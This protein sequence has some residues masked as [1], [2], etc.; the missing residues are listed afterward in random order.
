VEEVVA[1]L[2][3]RREA[4]D[5]VNALDARA[6]VGG[7]ALQH[8]FALVHADIKVERGAVRIDSAQRPPLERNLREARRQSF[9]FEPESG[10]IEV[11]LAAS[12]KPSVSTAGSSAVR[13]TME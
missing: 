1:R 10:A 4:I 9:A 11:V 2:H 7:V 5:M 8:A 13:S 6:L 3:V 12:L